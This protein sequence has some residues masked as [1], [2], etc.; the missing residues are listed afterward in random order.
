[1]KPETTE[2]DEY[3]LIGQDDQRLNIYMR[4]QLF[5]ALEDYS[6]R[7]S[8]REQVALL[9]GRQSENA[10]GEG[11]IL[12]EDAIEAP[13]GDR[14][15]FEDGMWKRARRIAAARHP[16]RTVV[17]W[18]H[19]HLDATLKPSEEERTVH[20]RHF[21]EER[22]LLYLVS[23]AADDRNFFI[24]ID[25]KL[26]PALGFR[27]YG[28]T[29]TGAQDDAVP[30]GARSG[31]N[32]VGANPEQQGR[33]IERKLDKIQKRLQKPPVTPKDFL[34][35][36][37][38]VINACLILFR[39]NP[40]VTVDTSA[41]ERGQADLSAQVTSIRGR[42]DK[43][44]GHLSEIRVL[45]EQ[46]KLAAGLEDIDDS[47]DPDIQEPPPKP[48]KTTPPPAVA[49]SQGLT[50]GNGAIK[51][52]KVEAGDTLSVLVDRFYP[53]SQTGTTNAFANFNR[54]SAPDYAIFP[55]DTLKV[56][57]LEALR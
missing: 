38:L 33:H 22:H 43:L 36:A 57:S 5:K 42:I 14:V 1:M 20:K 32:A 55:G 9:V 8:N 48:V 4:Y 50:G 7:E 29:Q 35:V 18:F 51:L 6:K 2:P 16:N 25:G 39:P 26:E 53:N 31:I 28:K 46:L 12:V 47:I 27:I 17:G 44:E 37:L 24:P 45:D 40:P 10:D 15:R 13:L 21:P 11:F 23:A 30:V 54:L 52:Y 41:L 19:T 3:F 34:I 49:S 56:P